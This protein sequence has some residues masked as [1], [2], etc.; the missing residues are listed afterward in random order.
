M[1]FPG[2]APPPAVSAPTGTPADTRLSSLE[3]QQILEVLA[4]SASR[5]EAAE[6]LGISKTTLW[7]K[8]KKYNLNNLHF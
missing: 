8:L 7:R 6:K 3:K 2:E 5:R 1:I 4:H